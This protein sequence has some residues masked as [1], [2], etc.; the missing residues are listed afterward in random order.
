MEKSLRR[1]FKYRLKFSSAKLL[2]DLLP[3][4][5]EHDILTNTDYIFLP[6]YAFG[7]DAGA[8]RAK[9]GLTAPP[10]VKD[11]EAEREISRLGK[12]IKEYGIKDVLIDNIGDISLFKSIDSALNLHLDYGFNITNNFTLAALGGFGISSSVLSSELNF[13]QIKDTVARSAGEIGIYA[14]GRTTLMLT[15]NCLILNSGKCGKNKA[16]GADCPKFSLRDRKGEN[17]PVIAADNHR[18]YV[19]NSVPIYLADRKKDLRALNIS[20]AVVN[21]TTESKEEAEKILYD[22]YVRKGNF[23]KGQDEYPKKFTRLY[24]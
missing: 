12:I 15:E 18:N 24:K 20:F 3:F 13:A 4:I 6:P 16:A 7:F 23:T 14:Y 9:L 19:M 2:K 1:G 11:G 21:F 5:Y 22:Y 17:F 8:V 10:I